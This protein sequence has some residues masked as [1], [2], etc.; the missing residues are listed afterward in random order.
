MFGDYGKKLSVFQT[1]TSPKKVHRVEKNVV[2][3]GVNVT[4]KFE[5]EFESFSTLDIQCIVLHVKIV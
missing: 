5:F 2:R 4:V 1:Q 3:F